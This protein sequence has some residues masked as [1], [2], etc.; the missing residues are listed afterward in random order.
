[1][2]PS[3]ALGFKSI[4]AKA[5]SIQLPRIIVDCAKQFYKRVEDEK[6]I[7]AKTN[8]AVVAACIIIACAQ[9]QSGRT[10]KEICNLTKVS[11]KE[12]GKIY[13]QIKPLFEEQQI[14]NLSLD[15]HVFRFSSQMDIDS[16]VQQAA[17]KVISS[18]FI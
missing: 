6:M 17:I 13:K 5:A 18:R 2:C 8:D 7:K 11:K 10:F 9:N 12:V 14:S 3:N 1:L 15:A 4:D 16:K